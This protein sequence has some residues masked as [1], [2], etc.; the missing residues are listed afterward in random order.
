M[1]ID[2]LKIFGTVSIVILLSIILYGSYEYYFQKPTP[3]V[4]NYTVQS[5]GKIEQ[6]QEEKRKSQHLITGVSISQNQVM[7]TIGW[8]W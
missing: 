1:I 7:G 6:K 4:N 2:W 5:G 8:L 3:I